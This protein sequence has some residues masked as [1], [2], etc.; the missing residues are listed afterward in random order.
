MTIS[1]PAPTFAIP[2]VSVNAPQPRT[3]ASSDYAGH[4]LL[5]LFYP[6][7]FSFVC[8]TELTSFSARVFDFE[9][10][11][12]RI[13][14]VSVDSIASHVEWLETPPADGGLGPL[15]FP[16]ASDPDGELAQKLGIWLPEKGVSTRGLF[17]IDPQGVLQY[18]VVH[19]L[20]VGRNVDEI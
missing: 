8:P 10:R 9:R 11:N 20:S 17:L 14:G 3:V 4:W 6:R 5:L 18:G 16:L 1:H 7:D 12:C 19:N 2:A 13:L 15:Q